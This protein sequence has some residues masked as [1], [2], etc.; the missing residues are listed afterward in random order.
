[1]VFRWEKGEFVWDE[2][3]G[4]VFGIFVC[5]YHWIFFLL[6]GILL[7]FELFMVSRV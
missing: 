6:G 7:R 2:V 1:M 5:G 3:G 4:G